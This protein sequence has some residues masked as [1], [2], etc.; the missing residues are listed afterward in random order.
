MIF[1]IRVSFNLVLHGYFRTF[2]FFL[3]DM[4]TIKMPARPYHLLATACTPKQPTKQHGRLHSFTHVKKHVILHGKP[5]EFSSACLLL[6]YAL[7]DGAM[8]A[9]KD[10]L[11]LFVNKVRLNGSITPKALGLSNVPVARTCLCIFVPSLVMAI[12]H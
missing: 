8:S 4:L 5:D 7:H 6:I 3:N 2:V 9:L 10:M 12:A 11:C 1:C